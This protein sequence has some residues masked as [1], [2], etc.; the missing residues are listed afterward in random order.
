MHTITARA[1]LGTLRTIMA[2]GILTA[3]R[4]A[5]HKCR[6]SSACVLVLM[7][8]KPLTTSR[9]NVVHTLNR[10]KTFFLELGAGCKICPLVFAM[11]VWC[12]ALVYCRMIQSN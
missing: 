10:D 4:V 6:M 7:T 8:K 2:G 5:R 11:L 1:Q 9:G 12:L 3:E